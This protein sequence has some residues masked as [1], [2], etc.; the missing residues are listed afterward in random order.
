VSA[1]ESLVEPLRH[2]PQLPQV[3]TD[4]TRQLGDERQRL[5]RFYDEMTPSQKI[6]FI[7]SEI[8]LQSPARN[9]RLMVSGYIARLLSTFVDFHHLGTV[10]SEKCLCT[11]PR[12]DYEPDIVFFGLEKSA[13]FTPETHKF[14]VPDLAIEVLSETTAEIDRGVKFEDYAANG[15]GE[16]WIVDAEKSCIEQYVLVGDLYE[17]RIKSSSGGLGSQ[18]IDGLETQAESLFNQER[19]LKALRSMMMTQ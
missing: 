12:N 7:D 13:T 10:E 2:S 15:V 9:V 11:F 4:L 19:N 14:P 8:V 5:Q 3:V 1:L 18:V 16:Y 17:L 6:E